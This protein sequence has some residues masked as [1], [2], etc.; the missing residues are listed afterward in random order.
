MK[1][2]FQYNLVNNGLM[3]L[4][5]YQLFLEMDHVVRGSKIIALIL[6]WIYKLH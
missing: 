4:K 1:I 5:N 2:F 3:D 6:N